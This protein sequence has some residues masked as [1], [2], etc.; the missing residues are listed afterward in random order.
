[1]RGLG[2]P[3]T[4]PYN[5]LALPEVVKRNLEILFRLKCRASVRGN[6]AIYLQKDM[7]YGYGLLSGPI[8]PQHPSLILLY[9]KAYYPV[10]RIRFR[11][12]LRFVTLSFNLYH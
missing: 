4:L 3:V 2:F 7:L 12:G 1:M 5:P 10:C 11:T 8:V 6:T 9:C